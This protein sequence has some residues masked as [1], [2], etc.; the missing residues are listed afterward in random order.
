MNFKL[1][2]MQRLIGKRKMKSFS[3]LKSLSLL[4]LS[5]VISVGAYAQAKPITGKITDETG[6]GLPGISVKVKNSTKGVTTDATGAY[7]IDV[8]EGAVLVI[9]SV[10]FETSEIRVGKRADYSTTLKNLT[11]SLGQVVVVG[12][13]TQKKTSLTGSVA[14]VNGKTLNELP[15]A[16]IDQAL[17]GRVTGVSVTNN[18]TPGSAPIIAIRGISSITGSI[19]PLYV[20]DGFPTGSLNTFDSRD[21]ESV[22]VLKDASA[23]AIYGS[24]ATNGVILIT[25]KKGKRNGRMQVNLESFVGFQ[26]AYKKIDLLNT[27]QYVEF[28]K[29][30]LGAST[31]AGVPRFKPA[32]FN[33]PINSQTSQ[34][35]AQTNTNWQDEYFKKNAMITQHS[36]SVSGGNEVSRFYSSAGYFDQDGIAQASSYKRGNFRIN[37]EHAISKYFTFGENLYLATAKQQVNGSEGGNRTQLA[38]VI[39][40][41]PYI[42]VRNPDNNGG[43]QGP[44]NSFDASDPRNPVE[45]A[46][47]RENYSKQL[48][49]LGS[50]FVEVNFT[51]WLKFRSTFGLDYSNNVGTGYTPIHDD[52]GTQKATIATIGQQRDL[53]TTL[54]YTQQLSFNKDFGKH[55]VGATAV[56]ETQ[57]QTQKTETQAG[58]Q[59]NNIIRAL[60]GATNISTG[61]STGESFIASYVGRVTYDYAN[62][63]LLSAS[64]RRDGLSLWAPGNKYQNFPAVSIGWR[65]DQERFMQ[66][67]KA[68]SELKIRAGYGLTGLDGIN[69][70]RGYYPWQVGVGTNISSYPFGNTNLGGLGSAYGLL[71]NKELKW[72]TTK[73]LNLGIDL[74]LFRNKITLVAEYFRRESDGNSLI[75]PVPTPFSFGFGGN[76]TAGNVANLVNKGFE[77]QVGYHKTEGAFKWDVSGLLTV[78]TNT[79]SKLN[80]DNPLVAGGD[81]DFSNGADITKTEVGQTIQYFY[82]YETD[83]IFQNADQVAN[84]PFQSSATRQ[85]DI[86]FKDLNGDG[87][88]TDADRTNLGSYLPK[89]TYSFNLSAG[90]KNFDASIFFQGTQGNKIFNGGRVLSEGMRRLFN[91]STAVLNAWTPANPNTTVP[92]II[93]GDPNENARVSDRW[94]EDGSYLRLKNVMLGYTLPENTLRTLTKGAVNRFRIY[95]S[96]QNLLTFTQYKG[97]DPEIGTKNGPLTNGI[98]YGQYPSARSFQVG[99]QVGF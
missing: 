18:G 1:A 26:S 33:A 58:N 78:L 29:T 5:I 81:P 4:L 41:Q 20:I 56:I 19:Q 85:G 73:G 49:I 2:T 17:Q 80:S 99:V 86:K 42:P 51:K 91:A 6:A 7:T 89:F 54:L 60:N 61:S 13:G 21:V 75:I 68:I 84:S 90:Y 27:D 67:I 3:L 37:S 43:F 28:A 55:T 83:G 63:Y 88:I 74:G 30:L 9:S 92:R 71:S 45:I 16:S 8:A 10:G 35:F 32:N 47:L 59:D 76:G 24:R 97:W 11:S 79:I 69:I 82:G 40:M 95:V 44:D 66:K 94:I 65:V 53:F 31:F 98:D 48:K 12:Y 77:L 14:S 15:V 23:A 34:T 93:N 57:G 96:S 38:N 70:G 22:E 64:L 50:A 62:K 25:T 36:V 46:L 39:R 72:E 87:K 52:K